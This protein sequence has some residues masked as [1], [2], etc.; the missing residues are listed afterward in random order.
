MRWYQKIQLL[1]LVGGVLFLSGCSWSQGYWPLSPQLETDGNSSGCVPIDVFMDQGD[2][3]ATSLFQTPRVEKTIEEIQLSGVS[4][5]PKKNDMVEAFGW[6]KELVDRIYWAYL[7]LNKQKKCFTSQNSNECGV[8]CLSE[9]CKCKI[10]GPL[11][12]Y[13]FSYSIPEY[14]LKLLENKENLMGRYWDWARGFALTWREDIFFFTGNKIYPIG[15]ESFLTERTDSS[16]YT[17]DYFKNSVFLQ[18]TPNY[19]ALDFSGWVNYYFND[20]SGNVSYYKCE[21]IWV[22]GS[23]FACFEIESYWSS[24]YHPIAIFNTQGYNSFLYYFCYK[25]CVYD[26]RF[27]NISLENKGYRYE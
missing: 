5:L 11:T 7:D 21:D 17:D 25:E 10:C 18:Y 4:F 13:I 12:G 27:G 9:H 24:I 23:W 20:F 15:Q 6:E 16:I 2:A 8:N 26:K 22:Y 19:K 1:G 3:Y 14:W